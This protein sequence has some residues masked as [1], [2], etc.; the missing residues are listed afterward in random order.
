VP[1]TLHVD[2]DRWR[3]H[4]RA[5]ADAHP[6][7]V[8]VAKGNGYGFGLPRLARKAD[9]L[10]VDTL[11]VGTYEDAQEVLPRFHGDVLVMSPWRAELG[12]TLPEGSYDGR[13]VH[14]L[15]RVGDVRALA[16]HAERTG[17]R[18]RVV[19]EGLTTMARHGLTRHQLAA[20]AKALGSLRLQGF[21]LHLPMAGGHLAEAEQWAAV[22]Q[23][24]R[25]DTTTMYVSHLTDAELATLAE[26]RPGLTIRP[27]IG[28]GLWLGDRGALRVRASVLDRHQVSRG[29]RIGYRQR[30]MPRAGTLLVVAGGTAHGIGLEAPAAMTS[31]RQRAVS[32]ARGTLEAAGLSLSPYRVGGKQRWFAEPPHMQASMLFLPDSGQAPD[33]GEEVA[34]DVRF[35]TTT[36]DRVLVS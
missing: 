11:A 36:F 14:T 20:A 4:L 28:T 19:V 6:G 10:G 34:V 25:L 3:R 1:L 30:P 22:L 13:L 27:R 31:V 35:T 23:T 29:E 18:H 21:A 5:V 7:I 24:S 32:M 15:G 33:I 8:P 26:R 17:T 9:W 12:D 16:E 2:G